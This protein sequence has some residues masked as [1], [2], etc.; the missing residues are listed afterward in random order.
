MSG[1]IDLR[2]LKYE[3][4]AFLPDSPF[5]LNKSSILSFS[6]DCLFPHLNVQPGNSKD[7]CPEYNI[8]PF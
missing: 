7:K 6:I 5:T 8:A 2:R 4:K 3:K 1:N